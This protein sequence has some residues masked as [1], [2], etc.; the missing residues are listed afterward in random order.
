MTIN[1]NYKVTEDRNVLN[2]TLR[3]KHKN[4]IN[5][6]EEDS[7]VDPDLLLFQEKD[8]KLDNDKKKDEE[9][10]VDDELLSDISKDDPN[11]FDN[12][13]KDILYIRFTDVKR[14][15]TK[16]KCKFEDGILIKNDNKEFIIKKL[17]GELERDW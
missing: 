12:I 10:N 13:E 11:D 5:T 14:V 1:D 3:D 2:T 4:K 7:Y 9:A 15:K 17:D 16:W 6:T 8:E